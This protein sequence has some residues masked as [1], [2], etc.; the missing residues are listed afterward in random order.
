[1][2]SLKGKLHR[3]Y[4]IGY[5]ESIFSLVLIYKIF[6]LYQTNCYNVIIIS[7]LEVSFKILS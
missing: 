7:I 6:I 5:I 2:Q 1:M 3:F 4:D